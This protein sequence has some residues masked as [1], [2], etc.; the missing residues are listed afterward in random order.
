[1]AAAVSS[2]RMVSR[3]FRG[4]RRPPEDDY[5]PGTPA[6]RIEMMWPLALDAWAFK[7]KPIEPR[8]QRHAVRIVRG[9][10]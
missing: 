2:A 9:R 1:M 4:G 5:V 6:E 3:V 10:G 8:L 7:G